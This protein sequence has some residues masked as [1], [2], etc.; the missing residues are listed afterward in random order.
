MIIHK[1]D[2]IYIKDVKYH[3]NIKDKKYYIDPWYVGKNGCFYIDSQNP[4]WIIK[5][6][7]KS[8]KII[9]SAINI[10]SYNCIVIHK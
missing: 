10:T 8:T 5:K 2:G 6:F 7:Y 1:N 4:E 9:I 3:V